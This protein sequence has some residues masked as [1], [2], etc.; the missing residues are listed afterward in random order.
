MECKS[1]RSSWPSMTFGHQHYSPYP[2]VWNRDFHMHMG[3]SQVCSIHPTG[4]IKTPND[5]SVVSQ[6][7]S[8]HKWKSSTLSQRFP[9][10]R[11]PNAP[12]WETT[13]SNVCMPLGA[14][15]RR[16]SL[17]GEWLIKVDVN[18]G[19]FL[20]PRLS[21]GE[22]AWKQSGILFNLSHLHKL[23]QLRLTLPNPRTFVYQREIREIQISRLQDLTA[24]LIPTTRRKSSGSYSSLWEK[25]KKKN[26]ENKPT[27]CKIYDNL[28]TH[29]PRVIS[30][31]HQCWQEIEVGNKR[32]MTKDE[33]SGWAQRR[34]TFV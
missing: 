10:S 6:L 32:Q 19:S 12:P 27:A 18:S 4:S 22:Q 26:V 30:I 2:P 11:P 34:I 7:F 5:F 21:R 9:S 29:S 14:V 3:D 16:T 33:V 31:Q 15:G 17:H 24:I 1:L 23:T 25:K 8:Y 28:E 13:S 20:N